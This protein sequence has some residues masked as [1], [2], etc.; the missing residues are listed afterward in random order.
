ML[1]HDS[2]RRSLSRVGFDP[3]EFMAEFLDPSPND[4]AN[5]CIEARTIPAASEYAKSHLAPPLRHGCHAPTP[6]YDKNATIPRL[7][8][9]SAAQPPTAEGIDALLGQAPQHETGALD[10]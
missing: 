6:I 1:T 2:H 3:Y 9:T 8:N 7:V 10:C 4:R 5:Q